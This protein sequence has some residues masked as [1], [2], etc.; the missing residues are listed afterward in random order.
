MFKIK[1][2]V[3]L[4]G[5]LSAVKTENYISCD[6]VKPKTSRLTTQYPE[7]APPSERR[8]STENENLLAIPR[9]DIKKLLRIKALPYLNTALTKE[10]CCETLQPHNNIK[11]YHKEVNATAIL[12]KIFYRFRG[13]YLKLSLNEIDINKIA[14][15]NQETNLIKK[16]NNHFATWDYEDELTAGVDS[17]ISGSYRKKE[18]DLKHSVEM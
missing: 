16:V 13:R 15:K 5:C 1:I 10:N 14:L 6:T 4:I 3:M 7:N 2:T 18:T 9:S 11:L 12:N 17:D 8:C